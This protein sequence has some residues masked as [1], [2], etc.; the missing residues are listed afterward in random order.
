M[1]D[2][3]AYVVLVA[4]QVALH[5]VVELGA[6]AVE[7]GA[8]IVVVALEARQLLELVELL[9]AH[10][11]VGEAARHHPPLEVGKV[12][13]G[14]PELA[15][16][17]YRR[18]GGNVVDHIVEHHLRRVGPIEVEHDVGQ[19]VGLHLHVGHDAPAV[20]HLAS[21]ERVEHVGQAVGNV[22]GVAP[23]AVLVVHGLYAPPAGYVVLA[24]GELERAVVWQVHRHLHQALAIGARAEHHSA[25]EVLQR[26][27]SDLAGAGRLAVDQHHYWHHR[28]NGLEP[29]LV[30]AVG[31]AQLA[32]RL[33]QHPALGHPHVYYLNGLG[34]RAAAVAPEV[35]H[36]ALGPLP[37]QV[38]EGA[39]HVL[40]ASLREAVQADVAHPA[41]AHAVVWY[42]GQLDV[43]ARHPERQLLA[44][45]GAP[46]PQSEGG[47]GLAAQ[48]L[49]DVAHRL[50]HHRRVVYRQYLV[51]LAQAHLG[52]GH[53]LVGLV[54]D[55][56]LYLEVL[57]YHGAYA[58]IL[59]REHHLKLLVLVFGVVLGVGVEAAQHGLD[60]VAYHL[61]RVER[62]DI[63][64]VEVLVDGVEYVEVLAHLEVVAPRLL[65]LQARRRHECGQQD[66]DASSHFYIS[67]VSSLSLPPCRNG[68]AGR[69]AA[70][71]HCRQGQ[72]NMTAKL[73][74]YTLN[75]ATQGVFLRKFY[76][77][78]YFF[79][80]KFA[81]L[82]KRHYLC[83]AIQK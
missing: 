70:G 24:G 8:G 72:A 29:R 60:A 17:G 9:A 81:R 66:N 80:E 26:T 62:V 58:G 38:D 59:A 22:L 35:E 74:D 54:D 65:R 79:A 69:T 39:A 31:L 11:V 47:A 36:E 2:E 5:V 48:P 53:A 63:H 1:L 32:P 49:A 30:L 15:R 4:L 55:H 37:L 50:A 41:G 14:Q 12:G 34:Q 3:L 64:Q 44:R 61:R 21:A 68:P 43:A 16:R 10:G 45:G 67:V 13:V 6:Q 82:A 7:L 40:G 57:A 75:P 19:R 56:A 25:V 23:A 20:A 73:T 27:G 71:G 42:L 77:Y 28:V 52:S 18:V 51:A 33:H 83:I 76:V 46:H 78:R